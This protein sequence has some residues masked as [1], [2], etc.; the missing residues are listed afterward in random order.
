MTNLVRKLAKGSDWQ[1][2]YSMSKDGTI[3]LFSNDYDL[4]LLQINFIR[5]LNFYSS[6]YLDIALNDVNEDVL[7]DDLYEDAYMMFKNSKKNRETIN[8]DFRPTNTREPNKSQRKSSSSWIF[9]KSKSE[10]K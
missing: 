4:T 1:T 3:K 10:K 2:L 7:K 8:T 6:L 5:Y 9:K